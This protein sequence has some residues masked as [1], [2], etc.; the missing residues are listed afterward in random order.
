VRAKPNIAQRRFGA[1]F[2]DY[3][4]SGTSASKWTIFSFAENL[5]TRELPTFSDL[6]GI[7][8]RSFAMVF[9]QS[10]SM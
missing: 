6:Y 2:A 8:T 9:F 10:D 1:L 3:H 4:S 7:L 5:G